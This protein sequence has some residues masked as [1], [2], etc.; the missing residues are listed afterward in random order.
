MISDRGSLIN[1]DEHNRRAWEKESALGGNWSSII[2]EET[3]AS[4]RRGEYAFSMTPDMRPIPK[5]WLGKLDGVDLLCL[6]GGGGQ[7]GP[8]LAGMGANVTVYD[9]STNQLQLDRLAA[10]KYQ[11]DIDT[12]SGDMRDLSCFQDESFDVIVHPASN[13]F[14]DNVIPVWN[15]CHRVLRP[16][17]RLIAMFMNPIAFA[18]GRDQLDISDTPILHF[19]VPYSDVK[20]LKPEELQAKIEKGEILEYGHTLEDLIGGQLRAGFIL[21]GFQEGYWGD[22]FDV[23]ADKKFPQ[24]IVTYAVKLI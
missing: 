19:S 5:D 16:N 18:F 6:A 1:P 7:Q 15:E 23:K 21:K 11:L 4:V 10:E 20:S 13:M 9:L 2:S 3:M 14:V 22:K 8:I 24:S 17:G 12:V